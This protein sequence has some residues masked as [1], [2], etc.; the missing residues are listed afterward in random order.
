MILFQ[1]E[2]VLPILKGRFFQPE[3]DLP[4]LKTETRRTRSNLRTHSYQKAKIQMLSTDYFAILYIWDKSHELLGDIDDDGAKTEGYPNRETYI[5]KFAEINKKWLNK[6]YWYTNKLEEIP[7]VVLRFK[8]TGT[9][10][11]PWYSWKFWA[12]DFDGTGFYLDEDK[13]F[14]GT[15]AGALKEAKRRSNAFEINHH[16]LSKVI[17]ESQ[18]RIG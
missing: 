11:Q 17:Y 8:L 10:P 1:P 18:G 2:H 5:A 14:L 7:V 16:F 3:Q 13:L 9:S 6:N 12:E 4:I 15:N